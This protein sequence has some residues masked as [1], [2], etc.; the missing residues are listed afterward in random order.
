[1]DNEQFNELMRTKHDIEHLLS[2]PVMKLTDDEQL[3]LEI[4]LYEINERIEEIPQ[5][6][7]II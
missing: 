2:Q 3:S 1:M 4:M 7:S 6:L 5:Q